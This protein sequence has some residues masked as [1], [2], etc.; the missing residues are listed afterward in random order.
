MELIKDIFSAGVVGQGGAGF[1]THIKLNTDVEYLLINGLECEPL[2]ATDKHIMLHH[3]SEVIKGI[4]LVKQHLNATAAYISIK[5]TNHDEITAMQAAIDEAGAPII[6]FKSTNYYPSGDEHML[7]YDITKR[8]VP[9]GGIPLD[10]G[11]VVNNIGTMQAIYHATQGRSI[12]HKFLTVTGHVQNPMVLKVPIGT[13][14]E[15][16]ITLA[17]GSTLDH[18]RLINGGP[19]MG[20]IHEQDEIPSMFV[21]K[22]TSGIILIEPDRN[23]HAK[24][25]D[26]HLLNTINRAK[27]ACIQCRLCTDMCPRYLIGHRLHPHKM[28]RV[29]GAAPTEGTSVAKWF[30]EQNQDLFQEALTC[31]ECGIC[32][33]YACPMDILPRQVN[34]LIKNEFLRHGLKYQ[35]TLG[36]RPPHA[37]VEYR[38]IDPSRL[39]ARMGLG[40]IMNTKPKQF[41]E[42][43]VNQVHIAL[44]QHIGKPALAVVNIG[45]TVSLGQLIAEADGNFSANIHASIAG[46]VQSI[47]SHIHI[48]GSN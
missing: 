18:F 41:H 42:P 29:L 40:N 24:L 25:Q 45:D 3:A 5:N 35:N 8:T 46:T 2:L 4:T 1:P 27:A 43:K 34:I 11:V 33:V 23:F 30:L 37:M 38:K 10:V 17:G 21:T 47:T 16:C 31:C 13:S 26:N 28:M 6:L 12:T 36:E 32:E 9:A 7:V 14:F 44:K 39:M 22:T 19:L 20:S 15:T 48:E